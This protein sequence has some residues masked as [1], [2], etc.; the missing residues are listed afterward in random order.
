MMMVVVGCDDDRVAMMTVVDF[1]DG[2][3]GLLG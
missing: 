3:G 2:D 1:H